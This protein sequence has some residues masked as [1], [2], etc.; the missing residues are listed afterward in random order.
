VGNVVGS[1]IFNIFWILGVNAVIR[2]LPFSQTLMSDVFM[3]FVA[4]LLLFAVMF[5]GKRHVLERGQGI[6]F[7]ALYLVYVAYLV[8]RG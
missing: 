8:I 4:T 5:I 2:P 7:I 6:F 3:T 1:N